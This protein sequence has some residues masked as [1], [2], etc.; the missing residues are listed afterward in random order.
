[1]G[2]H[3]Q[4]MLILYANDLCQ[5]VLGSQQNWIRLCHSR[6]SFPKNPTLSAPNSLSPD[7]YAEPQA[8]TS[9]SSDLH[10]PAIA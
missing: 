1:L 4:A 10:L 8:P 7:F 9:T 6:E 3:L 2:S 5:K